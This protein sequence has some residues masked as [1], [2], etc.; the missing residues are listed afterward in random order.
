MLAAANV[1]RGTLFSK[2]MHSKEAGPSKSLDVKEFYRKRAKSADYLRDKEAYAHKM[3]HKHVV[4][5]GAKKQAAYKR[6]QTIIRQVESPTKRPKLSVGGHN[7]SIREYRLTNQELSGTIL[8][9]DLPSSGDLTM[10]IRTKSSMEYSKNTLAEK[11]KSEYLAKSPDKGKVR[12][13]P[14]P[15]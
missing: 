10:K 15:F 3:K 7:E 1:H 11:H 6:K 4:K 14:T 8:E 12:R 5:S 13:G 9:P 2:K